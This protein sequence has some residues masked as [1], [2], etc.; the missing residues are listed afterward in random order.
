MV[1][2]KVP[3]AGFSNTFNQVTNTLYSDIY[4][5]LTY[6]DIQ[7][8][9]SQNI[10]YIGNYRQDLLNN[11]EVLYQ[12]LLVIFST[13]INNAYESKVFETMLGLFFLMSVNNT[14]KNLAN[15]LEI[16]L[17]RQG[18]SKAQREQIYQ[19][20]RNIISTDIENRSTYWHISKQTDK[21]SLYSQ[22]LLLNIASK[23]SRPLSVIARNQ[24]KT[25]QAAK[26]YAKQIE[27]IVMSKQTFKS[28]NFSSLG[29]ILP[30]TIQEGYDF[31]K[32]KTGWDKH[33]WIANLSTAVDPPCL[34]VHKEIQD[35]GD[36]F[37]NGLS[38]PPSHKQCYCSLRPYS[39]NSNNIIN[40]VNNYGGKG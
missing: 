7:F 3:I 6:S 16:E 29:D 26:K 2:A 20:I 39:F 24:A 18:Y 4:T 28:A 27:K 22:L 32:V 10:V 1:T 8:L 9:A 23:L 17:R 35:V 15:P 5:Q 30:D 19:N 34:G 11:R 37:T 36:L 38:N 40:I 31:T 12:A 21:A 25:P 14:L 33:Q 13:K